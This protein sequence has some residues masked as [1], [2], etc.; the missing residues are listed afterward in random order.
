MSGLAL[1]TGGSRGI[2]AA[3]AAR[4]EAGG[5]EVVCPPRQELDLADP[6]SVAAW[7][8]GQKGRPWTVLINNAGI[9][10]PAPI[11]EHDPG[12]WHLHQ[13][14][15]LHAPLQLMAALLPGM[16]QRRQGH[17]LAITSVW[18]TCAR[19]GRAHYAATKAGL[20]AACRIAA[21]EV[22]P[23][24]VLV[25]AL[26]P[27]YTATALTEANNTPEE[28]AAIKGRIPLGR[29]A[30]PEEIAEAAAWIV[31]SK[32]TYLTGQEILLDGGYSLP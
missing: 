21:L 10:H 18:T 6:A 11:E 25:N 29:L 15:N 26:S 2:G 14:V 3:I 7:V 24:G 32:N 27:G 19:A 17:I 20:V 9:N 1:V 30:R 4:L 31:S 5:C 23:D 8:A 16:R 12:R 13:Q 22:A 28:L